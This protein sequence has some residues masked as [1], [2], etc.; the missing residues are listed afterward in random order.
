VEAPVLAEVLVLDLDL[1]HLVVLEVRNLGYLEEEF[2]NLEES[3]QE[4]GKAC[5]WADSEEER[6]S[7]ER[8]EMA[9]RDRR[10]EEARRAYQM[11]EEAC[12]H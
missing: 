2:G 7:E 5:R 12:L 6:R 8:E 9:F 1:A 4:E 11:V 3:R 10:A